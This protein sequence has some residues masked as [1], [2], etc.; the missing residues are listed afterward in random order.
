LPAEMLAP[1]K[2]R[3]SPIPAA[4]PLKE[5]DHIA[6]GNVGSYQEKDE[7]DNR[8]NSHSIRFKINRMSTSPAEM[9]AT[10]MRRMSKLTAPVLLP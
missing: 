5:D 7:P 3:I 4:I 9:L 6:C 1:T 2:R 8:A 10:T